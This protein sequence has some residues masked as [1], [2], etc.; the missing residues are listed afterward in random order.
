MEGP[1]ERCG[2]FAATWD[3]LSVAPQS[4]AAPQQRVVGLKDLQ[5]NACVDSGP[6]FP[7]TGGLMCRTL[8]SNHRTHSRLRSGR[9]GS[10]NEG[11]ARHAPTWTTVTRNF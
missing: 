7:A 3:Q 9:S 10:P 4:G 5:K 1:R 2:V 8:I 11:W 6:V